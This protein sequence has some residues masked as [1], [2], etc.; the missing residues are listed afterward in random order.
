MLTYKY[1]SAL[2]NLIL[3]LGIPIVLPFIDVRI[4]AI[5]TTHIRIHKTTFFLLKGKHAL[6]I[7]TSKVSVAVIATTVFTSGTSKPYSLENQ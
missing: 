7:T 5:E 4:H 6:H 2:S 1:K 3:V